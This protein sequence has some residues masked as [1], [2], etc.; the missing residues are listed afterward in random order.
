MSLFF[1]LHP[2]E[3]SRRGSAIGLVRGSLCQWTWKWE[4]ERHLSRASIARIHTGTGWRRMDIADIHKYEKIFCANT[5]VAWQCCT[6]ALTF[7][8]G[9]FP[10]HE[11]CRKTLKNKRNSCPHGVPGYVGQPFP[12]IPSRMPETSF[13]ASL[14]L[15][16]GRGLSHKQRDWRD[17]H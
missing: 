12:S 15:D 11:Q 10:A 9:G 4:A 1:S 5:W 13:R 3:P 7:K 14:R 17:A 16:D 8:V 6:L 2:E